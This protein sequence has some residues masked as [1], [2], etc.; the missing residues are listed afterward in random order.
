[1]Y[2][3]SKTFFEYL[4]LA[5]LERIHSQM[6]AWLLSKDCSVLN[7]NQQ[8]QFL[9][10]LIGTEIGPIIQI[11][12]EHKNIDI[13]IETDQEWI[14]I[15]N[16]ISSSQ[17]SDQL[18]RY[19]KIVKEDFKD[20][21]RKYF[22]F[23]TLVSESSKDP[24]KD[25]SYENMIDT[26]GKF[27]TNKLLNKDTVIFNEYYLYLK[28]LVS[29]TRDF[30]DYPYNY[31]NVFTDGSLTKA[32]KVDKIKGYNDKQR[33][34]A[35]NQLETIL[36]KAYL[37][38]VVEILKVS[39]NDFTYYINETRGV[40]LLDAISNDIITDINGRKFKS[41][42]QLQGSTVKFFICIISDYGKSDRSWIEP[43]KRGFEEIQQSTVCDFN[44]LNMPKKYAWLSVSKQLDKKVLARK[45]DELVNTL[46]QELK[47]HNMLRKK[48]NL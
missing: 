38:K 17:H 45:Y 22:L 31:V 42:I 30:I 10:E 16:K 29:T 15:E 48:L 5:H 32:D 14:V 23:L 39:N 13:L 41:G 6:L 7:S 3:K 8:S 47:N 26:L 27:L 25:I 4:G 36:Q 19:E 18:N 40:A 2:I 44:S 34:I 12:T 33:F 21:K 20:E 37:S 46:N 35:E 9:S 24:W 11:H 28:E 43:F 1:M